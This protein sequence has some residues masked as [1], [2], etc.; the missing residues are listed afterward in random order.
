MHT[1]SLNTTP[2]TT[3]ADEPLLNQTQLA[4]A[5]HIGRATVSRWRVEG[6]EMPYGRWTTVSHAKAWLRDVY[7]PRLGSRAA[8]HLGFYEAFPENWPSLS[9]TLLFSA[10]ATN[11]S[12]LVP[13][14]FEV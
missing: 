4:A 6:Y 8:S 10:A 1:R 3:T 7:A 13:Q 11:P 9:P 14:Q 5:L 2:N 12:W